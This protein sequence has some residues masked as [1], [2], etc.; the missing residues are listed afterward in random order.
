MSLIVIVLQKLHSI[1]S[2]SH[3]RRPHGFS[4]SFQVMFLLM[5][6]RLDFA[7]AQLLWSSLQNQK[8]TWFPKTPFFVALIIVLQCS[9]LCKSHNFHKP[10]KLHFTNCN[11]SSCSLVHCSTVLCQQ[12]GW[13]ES[14]SEKNL[15]RWD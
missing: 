10:G 3:G 8:L 13:W 9:L 1:T 5:I 2:V 15:T 6:I 4:C 14:R 7:I 11:T 12:K